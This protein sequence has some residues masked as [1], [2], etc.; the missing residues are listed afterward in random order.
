MV[1]AGKAEERSEEGHNK[2]QVSPI[3]SVDSRIV[4]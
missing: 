4:S 3:E 2:E 1:V